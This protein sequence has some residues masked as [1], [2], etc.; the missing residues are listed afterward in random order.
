M[1]EPQDGSS[2]AGGGKK[3]RKYNRKRKSN[4]TTR[5]DNLKQKIKVKYAKAREDAQLAGIIPTTPEGA[6]R[7]ERVPSAPDPLRGLPELVRQ[8]LRESWATPDAAKPAVIASLLRPFY[9]QMKALD[10][11]GKVV[12]LSTPPKTLNELA[13]T[14]MALDQTQYERDNPEAAGKAKGAGT[15]TTVNVVQQNIEAAALIRQAIENGDLGILEEVQTPDKPSASGT[16]GHEREMD[17][18][19]ALE[20]DE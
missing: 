9:E 8:A 6:V 2:L 5:A 12:E 7:D 10:V 15:G 13:R 16:G 19:T 14:L 17:S 3:K 1:A 11:E 18:S 20:D 4:P